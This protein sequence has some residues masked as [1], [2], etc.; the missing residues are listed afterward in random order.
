LPNGRIVFLSD[1]PAERK[2][3][4]EAISMVYGSASSPSIDSSFGRT[5]I[6]PFS[7]FKSSN[8]FR[9][10]D[11]K[12]VKLSDD[13][14]ERKKDLEAISFAYPS[15]GKKKD[16]T[17]LLGGLK[18]GAK[19][20]IQ[21]AI[22]TGWS[23]L[24]TAVGVTTPFADLPVEKRL[25][26][27]AHKRAMKRD[28]RYADKTMAQVGMGLGQVG[29]MTGLRLAGPWGRVASTGVGISLNMSEAMRKIAD[30]E[31]RTGKDVPWY[32]ESMAH[33]AGAMI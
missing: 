22:E 11:G 1:D 10:P 3:D 6:D 8:N 30:Y 14:E 21:G 16:D 9:L 29:T 28:P 27:A 7:A 31:Q 15:V 19:S 33:M 20:I 5:S 12:I 26:E 18:A 2:K 24:E 4:L 32:K 17:T 25:R 13:P 23:M